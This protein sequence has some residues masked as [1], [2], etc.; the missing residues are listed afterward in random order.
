[1][2]G[3]KVGAGTEMVA[4]VSGDCGAEGR[5][6]GMIWWRGRHFLFAGSISFF[7]RLDLC[8]L[9]ELA[10]DADCV[11]YERGNL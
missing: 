11:R 5:C 7:Y 6:R 10:R 1:M 4:V 2:E 8:W 3:G 9:R